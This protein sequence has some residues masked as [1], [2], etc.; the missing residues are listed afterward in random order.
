MG[1]RIVMQLLTPRRTVIC[2]TTEWH[3]LFCRTTEW[4]SSFCET[5]EWHSLFCKTTQWYS[6]FCKSYYSLLVIDSMLFLIL[7][8]FEKSKLEA[9]G[10]SYCQK[11]CSFRNV[12]FWLSLCNY[13]ITE[14]PEVSVL[15]YFELSM[16]TIEARWRT[17]PRVHILVPKYKRIIYTINK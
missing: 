1:K 11:S 4:Q 8:S 2:K 17:L 14:R 15:I 5:T 12:E 13:K 10:H 9:R 6:L 16:S 3:S 7:L